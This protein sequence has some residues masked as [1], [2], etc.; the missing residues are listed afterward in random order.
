MQEYPYLSIDLD[1]IRHNAEVVCSC[2]RK[3]GVS[4][5]GVIKFSDGQADIAKA[6]WDGG[7]VEVA[8][9]RLTHLIAI[10]QK[11][12]YIKNLLIR[13]PMLCEVKD[14]VLWCD[15]SLNTELVTLQALNEAA[16]I[17]GKIHNVILLMDVGDLREGVI[18]EEELCSLACEVERHMPYLYL[19]GIG[20]TFCCYG[21]ILPTK[22]N[23]TRLA[24]AVELVES[25]I[26]RPLETISGGS[27]STMIP[28]L[29][30]DVP[31]KINHLRIGGLIANPVSMRLNR[32]FTI[33]GIR[34]DSFSLHGQVIENSV[35]PT[36]P[37]GTGSTNWAGNTV[38]YA[39][40]GSRRR[41][42]VA[43]GAADVGDVMKLLPM[44]DRIKVLGGSSDHLLLDIED[45]DTAYPVG[46]EI[47][48]RML[49]SALLH[50]FISRTVREEYHENR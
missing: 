16:A 24:K 43:L 5:A 48:F 4:V 15:T 11:Y 14:T 20:S 47:T 33:E 39:D 35:K 36:V 37:F 2:C 21:G 34:E 17:A 46:S 12:P 23:L 29:R 13:L 49:Y 3:S 50:S 32:N 30:R 40:R 1:A 18:T 38:R 42:I 45:C 9:S 7:C 25:A 19:R 31:E 27:S 41:A 22:A 28:L 10:K 8:S 44:D 26:G 6:Y